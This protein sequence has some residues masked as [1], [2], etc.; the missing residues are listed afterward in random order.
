VSPVLKGKKEE[1]KRGK[2]EEERGM[3]ASNEQVYS[4]SQTD[5]QIDRETGNHTYRQRDRQTDT[6]R[7]LIERFI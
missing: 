4:L 7:L 6:V 3:K 2:K 5:R 1:K